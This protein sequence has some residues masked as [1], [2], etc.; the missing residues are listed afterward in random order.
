VGPH[1]CIGA[2]ASKALIADVAL[3][4]LFKHLQDVAIDPLQPVDFGGWA[5]RGLLN[6][7]VVWHQ[8]QEPP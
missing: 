7:P 6:L 3:P 8:V 2:A 5:V 1:F 4:T